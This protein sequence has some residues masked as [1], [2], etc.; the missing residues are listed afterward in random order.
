MMDDS[1]LVREAGRALEKAYAPYSNFR[2]GACVLT[3]EGETY[4]ACNVE[5]SSLGLTICAERAAIFA[6][7]AAG[8]T[9]ID[10][11]AVVGDSPTEPP[12]PCGACLQVMSEFGVRTVVVGTLGGPARPYGLDELLPRPFRFRREA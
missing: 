12:L 4:A 3:P 11:V 7:V 8:H 9:K 6:A 10:K 2:V 5:N 1:E